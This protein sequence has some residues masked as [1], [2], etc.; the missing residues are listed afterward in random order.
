MALGS[1][2]ILVVGN[3]TAQRGNG[4]RATELVNHLLGQRIAQDRIDCML[5]ES[6]EHATQLAAR[7]NANTIVV[8]GG[9]G[10]VHATVN[11]LMLRPKDERP[12]LGLIPVG[13][14]NDY[15]RTL[16][17]SEHIVQ[18]VDQLVKASE[19]PLDVGCCNGEYFVQTLSFGLDAAIAL[20]TVERR[21]RTGKKDMS[22]YFASG[23]DQLFHHLNTYQMQLVIE[24]ADVIEDSIYLIAVQ[25]G[26]TYGGGFR[27]CPDAD[28]AD[29][30]FDICYV[31]APMSVAQGTFIFI[32]ARNA[33]HTNF[34]NVKFSHGRSLDLTFDRRPA[35]QIDGE[36]LIA[37]SYHVT[38]DQQAMRVLMP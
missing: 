20:D 22:L 33:H 21:K 28:P 34:K 26:P 4:E 10:I 8:V 36:P 15:A 30:V 17:M 9:D 29:G 7:T 24:N 2:K 18:A 11:G 37:D 14:G 38:I 32:R 5:S 35:V 1:G 31:R 13:S 23:I 12:A 19:T 16:G 6:A 27:I 25:I 3:P